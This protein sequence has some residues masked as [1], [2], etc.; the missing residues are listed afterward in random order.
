MCDVIIERVF[1]I[2]AFLLLVFCLSSYHGEHEF[3]VRSDHV[4]DLLLICFQNARKIT[5]FELLNEPPKNRTDVNPW[6]QWPRVFRI[7]YGHEEV[8][9]IL[10]LFWNKIIMDL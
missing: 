2:N 1:Y 4:T 9:Y 10:S 5:T 7:E 8:L 6:P 3:L